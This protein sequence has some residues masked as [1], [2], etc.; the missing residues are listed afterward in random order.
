[1]GMWTEWAYFRL[2]RRRRAMTASPSTGAV[3]LVE[4]VPQLLRAK[5]LGAKTDIAV[6]SYINDLRFSYPELGLDLLQP[7]D[8]Y[9]RVVFAQA[10]AVCVRLGR[11][12]V[13]HVDVLA[14]RGDTLVDRS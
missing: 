7:I 10:G 3:N 13:M 5:L 4:I 6:R 2:N 1:M 14:E 11:E 8:D 12:H 9:S